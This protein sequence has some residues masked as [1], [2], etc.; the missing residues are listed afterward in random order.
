M[1]KDIT[2]NQVGALR[3]MAMSKGV[4]RDQFQAAFQDGRLSR[5]L[6]S[7]K[8]EEI[9][10]PET[11]EEAVGAVEQ[12]NFS[13]ASI[14]DIISFLRENPSKIPTFV[15]ALSGSYGNELP[16]ITWRIAL[17]LGHTLGFSEDEMRDESWKKGFKDKLE[18]QHFAVG[19]PENLVEW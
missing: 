17:V 1:K 15:R 19:L 14:T 4:T 6:N 12:D 18:R 16:D 10:P 13:H 11:V 3:R 9:L 8:E 2:S 5:F 7:L